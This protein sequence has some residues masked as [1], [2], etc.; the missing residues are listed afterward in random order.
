MC[1]L[2]PRTSKLLLNS[3]SREGKAAL[4]RILVAVET[5][6]FDLESV[7]LIL[8]QMITQACMEKMDPSKMLD[9][10]STITGCGPSTLPLR[11]RLQSQHCVTIPCM[12]DTFTVLHSVMTDV[13]CAKL[14]V[15]FMNY[16]WDRVKQSRTHEPPKGHAL[17][18]HD[19]ADAFAMALF[20]KDSLCRH[21]PFLSQC[22]VVA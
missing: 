12:T 1:V 11:P 2:M 22:S 18:V 17:V 6:F 9:G 3:T 14:K 15:K 5:E 10:W 21:V 8:K 20:C 7:T 13:T 19:I 4:L 16:Y